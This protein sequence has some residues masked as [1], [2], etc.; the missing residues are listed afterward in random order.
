MPRQTRF[1]TSSS[2]EDVSDRHSPPDPFNSPPPTLPPFT[3]IHH[4]SRMGAKKAMSLILVAA[5]ICQALTALSAV[6]FSKPLCTLEQICELHF[7]N[8]RL[9]REPELLLL[10]L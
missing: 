4:R 1:S 10:T 3:P 2:N 8:I 7:T 5:P 6:T 9:S